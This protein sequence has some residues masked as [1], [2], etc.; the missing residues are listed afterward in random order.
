MSI[1]RD[2]ISISTDLEKMDVN[3]IHSFLSNSYWS[4][5][6]PKTTLEK[7]LKHSFCFALFSF[8]TQIGFARV[9]TDYATFAYVADLFIDSEYRN[10]G[11]GLFLMR[12]IMDHEELQGMRVWML[13]TWDAHSLYEKVGF[14]LSQNPQH[15]MDIVD[16][17]IYKKLN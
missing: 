9:I 17:D 14:K 7:A 6:I 15:I 1:D 4:K 8:N 2:H 16:F 13:R 12:F 3:Y 5:D 10:K 11:L